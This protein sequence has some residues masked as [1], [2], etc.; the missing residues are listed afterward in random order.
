M[1]RIVATLVLLAASACGGGAGSSGSADE[2]IAEFDAARAEPSL[3][4]LYDAIRADSA[5]AR[6]A[7]LEHLA[8]DDRD[9]RWASAFALSL[10]AARGESLDALRP[11]LRSRDLDE[12]L[13]AAGALAFNGEKAGLPPL[14]EAITSTELLRFEDPPRPGW[15]FA[16]STL[17][18]LT[19]ED[20]GLLARA[21]GRWDAEATQARWKAWWRRNEARVAW[22]GEY[23]TVSP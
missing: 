10:T 23:F 9:V 1:R 16:R 6:A 15:H 20:L 5:E 4:A 7:A 19:D 17:I 14:I 13:L 22:N 8:D 18:Q 12:R 3:H 11:L 21:G 2:A